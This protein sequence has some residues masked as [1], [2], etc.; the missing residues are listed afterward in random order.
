MG[1]NRVL[2]TGG[3]GFIGSHLADALLKEGVEVMVL[4]NLSTGHLENLTASLEHDSLDVVEGDIR[5]QNLLKR[6]LRGVDAV[7]HLAA[8]V[9]VPYS[10]KWPQETFA[11]NREGTSGLLEA[12]TRCGVKR[13]IY[14]STCAVY[15]EP[16]YLPID[17]GHPTQPLSPYAQSKLEAEALCLAFHRSHELKVTV[18]RLFNV[19]GPRQGSGPYSGVITRFIQRLA[20]GKAPVI[21]GD[22]SQTRD[23]VHVQDVVH[24]FT[25]ALHRVEAIGRVFNVAT[26]T[27]TSLSHLAQV[28]IQLFK[29]EDIHPEYTDPRQGD[30]K[31]SYANIQAAQQYLGFS[32]HTTLEAGL[33]TLVQSQRR[34]ANSTLAT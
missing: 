24:A 29:A 5:D 13:V 17:E 7:F 3:A 30:I 23:F 18:L 16:R 34:K 8:V 9:S 1:Y 27:P 22:G 33:S 6:V 32:P 21:F 31:H 2:I 15:G 10:V 11:V 4:D 14:T 26:G 28:M 19:Y 20:K 25:H 12:C